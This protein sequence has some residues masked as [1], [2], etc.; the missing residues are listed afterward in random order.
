MGLK[1]VIFWRKGSFWCKSSWQD[2]H[3][4]R[5]FLLIKISLRERLF[6]I[7]LWIWWLKTQIKILL[8]LAF[9]MSLIIERENTYISVVWKLNKEVNMSW[10]RWKHRFECFEGNKVK[11]RLCWCKHFWHI[12]WK[13]TNCL[14]EHLL[15]VLKGRAHSGGVCAENWMDFSFQTN[16]P[17]TS[18]VWACTRNISEYQT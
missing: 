14:Q 15:Y 7:Y 4:K 2:S 5:S 12:H 8:R 9:F 11:Y 18:S 6:L 13:Q 10:L 3:F 1:I 16:L 17:H